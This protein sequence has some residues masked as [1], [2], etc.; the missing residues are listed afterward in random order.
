MLWRVGAVTGHRHHDHRH[1]EQSDEER[2]FD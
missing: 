1:A 2:D